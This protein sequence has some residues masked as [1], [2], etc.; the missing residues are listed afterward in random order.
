MLESRRAIGFGSSTDIPVDDFRF[1]STLNDLKNL[2]IELT[3]GRNT[4]SLIARALPPSVGVL[5]VALRTPRCRP[6]ARSL[7]C[8]LGFGRSLLHGP[9]IL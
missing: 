9:Y 5:L 1:S 2:L 8:H 3:G 7:V 6:A 4:L